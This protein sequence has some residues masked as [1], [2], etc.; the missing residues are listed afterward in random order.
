MRRHFIRPECI[1]K[2]KPLTPKSCKY[3]EKNIRQSNLSNIDIKVKA[4]SVANAHKKSNSSPTDLCKYRQEYSN[5]LQPS[6]A[7]I[8]KKVKTFSKNLILFNALSTPK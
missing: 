5:N 8:D 1:K 4:P 6:P 3:R 7:N 2:L